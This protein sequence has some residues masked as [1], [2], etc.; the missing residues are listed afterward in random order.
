[1]KD[2]KKTISRVRK[3]NYTNRERLGT[4]VI[5]DKKK[6]I[7]KKKCRKKVNTDD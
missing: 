4:M 1:M 6:Q 3:K 2:K 5:K 7:N